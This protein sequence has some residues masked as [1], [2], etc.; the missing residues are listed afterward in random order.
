M[1]EICRYASHPLANGD[2]RNALIIKPGDLLLG[3]AMVTF[4][5][6]GCSKRN[7]LEIAELCRIKETV[8]TLGVHKQWRYYNIPK[9]LLQANAQFEIM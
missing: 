5:S 6:K 7:S 9:Q 3:I 2:M 1:Q 8:H 4:H